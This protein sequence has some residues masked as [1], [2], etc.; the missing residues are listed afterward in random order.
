MADFVTHHCGLDALVV[1]P[2]P[3][4]LFLDGSSCGKGC[5]IGIVL[6]LP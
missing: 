2:A 4:T 1:E 3:W 6:I 5:G